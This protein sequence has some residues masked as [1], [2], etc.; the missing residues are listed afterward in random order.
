MKSIRQFFILV[1]LTFL[2]LS[3]FVGCSQKPSSSDVKE[4]MGNASLGINAIIMWTG[5]GLG[6]N[7]RLTSLEVKEWG[8]YNK[9]GNYW[10]ARARVVGT[11]E[12]D[13]I[14]RKDVRNF[15]QIGE[16]KFSKDD[17]G[18]WRVEIETGT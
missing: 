6:Q 1:I 3:L 16:C 8:N 17:Y 7:I 9:E 2:T 5:G 12:L 10:P 4:A 15:D 13:A 18:K 14:V 11:Y